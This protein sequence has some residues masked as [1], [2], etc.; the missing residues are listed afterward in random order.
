MQTLN[1]KI[2]DN[3][4]P[5]FRAIIES[6]VKDNKVRII[7]DDQYDFENNY[8]QSLVIGTVEEVRKRVFEAEERVKN[9]HY[10][11]EEEYNERMDK[12]FK[13]ELGI[14]R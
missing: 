9:G 11:T 1:L 13:D 8:P 12:F 14:D 4:F 6:F 2:D 5:H 3:F 10:V 7:E